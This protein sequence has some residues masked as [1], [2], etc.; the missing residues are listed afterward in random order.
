MVEVAATPEQREVGLMYRR[1]LPEDR[2]MLFDFGQATDISM[3]MENTYVSLDMVF[4]GP[5]G[6][7]LRIEEGAEPLSR[8]LIESGAPA[9]F[10]VELAAGVAAKFSLKPG[11]RVVHPRVGG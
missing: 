1:S 9:R 4:V 3:W 8:R 7:V 11:D 5:D 2:G 6:R 10:V